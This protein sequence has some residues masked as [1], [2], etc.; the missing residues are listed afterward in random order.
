[1]TSD[2]EHHFMYL[3]VIVCLLWKHVYSSPLSSFNWVVLILV[4]LCLLL[5]C[6]SFLYIFNINP[7]PV[8][9]LANIFSH[10]I[11]CLFVLFDGFLCCVVF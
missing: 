1:M 4:L 3:L 10:S 9:W 7:L 5:S 2:V 6:M 11:G 8:M